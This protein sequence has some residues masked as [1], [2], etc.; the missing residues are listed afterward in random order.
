MQA[1]RTEHTARYACVLRA[2][3]GLE[4]GAGSD[5][6]DDGDG[7]CGDNGICDVVAVAE[8]DTDDNTAAAVVDIEDE[9]G[10]AEGDGALVDCRTVCEAMADS[11]SSRQWCRCV[12]A[13]AVTIAA[14][15]TCAEAV[16][17]SFC[18]CVS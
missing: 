17:S 6:D 5:G 12:S 16:F 18:V 14:V 7:I 15:C 13:F 11:R 9:D 2:D 4:A 3:S 1:G 8:G 10:T